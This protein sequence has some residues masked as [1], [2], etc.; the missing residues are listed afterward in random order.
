MAVL[1]YP[2]EVEPER[3][4]NLTDNRIANRWRVPRGAGKAS[5]KKA[6]VGNAHA[7]A[8]VGGPL[9]AGKSLDPESIQIRS[10]WRSRPQR[11]FSYFCPVCGTPHRLPFSLAPSFRHYV[12]VGLTTLVAA[13]AAWPVFGPKGFVLF[14][15]L[16]MGFEMF[17]RLRARARM[18]CDQC[19]FDPY[20]YLVDAQKARAEIDTHFKG[21]FE[22]KGL[23]WPPGAPLVQTGESAGGDAT[24]TGGKSPDA[25]TE[26]ASATPAAAAFVEPTRRRD[27]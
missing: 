22:A 17:F 4:K 14:V 3:L 2:I 9:N 23:G 5:S 19:A 26:K 21:L 20:L 16:W 1:S 6:P 18:R 27:V 10:L 24:G 25:A 7:S 13:I 8:S 15:P 11:G 12:Q